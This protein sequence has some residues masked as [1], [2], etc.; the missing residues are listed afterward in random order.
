MKKLIF[1]QSYFDICK[2]TFSNI[3]FQ[4]PLGHKKL[5]PIDRLMVGVRNLLQ[6]Y[7]VVFVR[8]FSVESIGLLSRNS[9]YR[10]HR[11]VHTAIFHR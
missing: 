1:L 11:V 3:S 2:S 6:I 8:F 7:Y 4:I 5:Q 10:P 9:P